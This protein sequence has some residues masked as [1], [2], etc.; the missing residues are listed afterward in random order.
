MD[1]YHTSNPTSSARSEYRSS[2]ESKNPPKRVTRFVS[3]AT[4]PSTMSNNPAPMITTPAQ[5][6]W[7]T[8][9]SVAAAMLIT[10]PRN[11]S[12]FGEIFDSASPRTI[13]RITLLQELPIARVNV[14]ASLGLRG[15]V[16]RG[17]FDD[18]H[19]PEA[20]RNLDADRVPHLLAQQAASD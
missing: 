13:R 10:R 15:L 9:S 11:V 16:N 19:F 5:R 2:T 8:A 6:N 14:M 4:R 17:H 1:P 20:A 18:F 7:P 3:L 12:T